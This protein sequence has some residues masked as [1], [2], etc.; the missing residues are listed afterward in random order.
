MIYETIE[1]SA[2]GFFVIDS[3]GF[4]LNVGII[5]HND[6]GQLLWCRRIW[7]NDAWQFPQGGIQEGETPLMAMYRELEEEL[8][9]TA[10]DVEVVAESATWLSYILPPEF[11]RYYSK[12]LCIGQ[13]QKWYLLHLTS[14]VDAIQLAG[15]EEQEFDAW[16]WVDYW[17]PLTDVIEFK[18]DVYQQVLTEFAA[19]LGNV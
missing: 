17:Y 18:H 13:K 15:R 10:A 14:S 3:E 4:R 16:R 1:A 6:Q 5:I 2:G 19:I 7:K 12:P 8:G 9:L 11:R